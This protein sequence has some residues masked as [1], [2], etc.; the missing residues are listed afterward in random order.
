MVS[1]SFLI[2]LVVRTKPKEGASRYPRKT[3]IRQPEFKAS[4]GRFY[5]NHLSLADWK[6]NFNIATGKKG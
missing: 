3:K 4:R 5:N 6:Q 1:R 2:T